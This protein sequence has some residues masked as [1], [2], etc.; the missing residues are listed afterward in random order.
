MKRPLCETSDMERTG[1]ILIVKTMRITDAAQA[2][3]R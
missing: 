1:A 2:L 3:Y